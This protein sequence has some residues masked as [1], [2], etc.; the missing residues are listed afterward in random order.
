MEPLALIRN[1]I[2]VCTLAIGL[3]FGLA[4]CSDTTAPDPPGTGTLSLHLVD[5]PAAIE[6]V[7]ALDVVF[8]EVRVHRGDDADDSSGGWTVVLADSLPVSERSF[9]LLEL[10]NGVF[11]TLGEVELE[12]GR[13]TQIRIV[14]ESATVTV[15]STTHDLF[16]PSGAQS[17]LK[18]VGGFTVE[19]DALNEV[20]LDFDVARSLHEAPPGS[21]NYVLRPTIRVH[22]NRSSGRI[23]GTVLPTGIDAVVTAIAAGDTITST[24]VDDATGGYVLSCLPAGIYDVSASAPGYTDS[25][26]T[27]IDVVAGGS[28]SDVDFELFPE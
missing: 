5:A 23:A 24:L 18:L 10:V 27:G 19:A 11:A 20:T 3:A 14:L 9:D 15:D 13:Y 4:A 17:G 25:I 2:A 6:G 12:A 16:V 26:R 7:T 8:E 21:G 28:A 22:E 1:R